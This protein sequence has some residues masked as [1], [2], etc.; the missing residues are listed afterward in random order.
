MYQALP[1]PENQIVAPAH[2]SIARQVVDEDE[3]A[4]HIAE[5]PAG[6]EADGTA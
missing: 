3:L 6:L 4:E 2:S 1:F 5:V